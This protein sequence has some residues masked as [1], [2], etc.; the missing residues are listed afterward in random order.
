MEGGE[1][2]E[3]RGEGRGVRGGRTV[4]EK[5]KVGEEVSKKNVSDCTVDH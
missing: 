4:K 3:T 2:E 5:D 1:V